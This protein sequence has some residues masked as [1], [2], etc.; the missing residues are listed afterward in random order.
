MANYFLQSRTRQCIVIKYKSVVLALSEIVFGNT[1]K[2]KTLSLPGTMHVFVDIIIGKTTNK[3]SE[4]L[5][6]I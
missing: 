1:S 6:K 2:S 5:V 4:F 3:N